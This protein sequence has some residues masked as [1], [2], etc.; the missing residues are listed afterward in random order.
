MRDYVKYAGILFAITFVTALLLGVVNN[1]TAPVIENFKYEKMRAAIEV[2][3]DGNIDM[4]TEEKH[5]VQGESSVQEITSY[6]NDKGNRVYAVKAVPVGYAGDIEMMIGINNEG[7]V[8]GVE[9]INMS[10][11]AGLGA[12]AKGNTEW[13]AQFLGKGRDR[14]VSIT[15]ATITSKA[16]QKGVNDARA[17]VEKI[18]GG[19]GFE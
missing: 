16:V 2:V 1:F 3:V 6:M 19:V 8:T 7:M 10:E 15:G 17:Q 14:L 4:A 12:N 13:L 5:N 11:T 18:A 9:I